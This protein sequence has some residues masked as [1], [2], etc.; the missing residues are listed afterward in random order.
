MCLPHLIAFIQT[1]KLQLNHQSN[2]LNNMGNLLF[3]INY[4]YLCMYDANILL[5]LISIILYLACYANNYCRIV[6][7]IINQ[8]LIFLKNKSV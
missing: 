8:N 5:Y 7:L 6:T 3:I 2:H 4:I 1:N